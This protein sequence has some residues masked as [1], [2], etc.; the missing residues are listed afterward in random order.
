MAMGGYPYGNCRPGHT[1]GVT[2]FF[3]PIHMNLSCR[4]GV[5]VEE[6]HFSLESDTE[7]AKRI[8][9][10]D[11]QAF[12]RLMQ[13]YREQIRRHLL[14]IVRD[15]AAAEDL[16]QDV[17]LRLWERASQW[18]RK[19][20]FRAWLMRMAT[21]LA[22]NHLRSVR[23]GRER[24]LKPPPVGPDDD[25]EQLAPGWMVD[26]SALG[27]DVI[28]DLTEQREIL[29]G[30]LDALPDEKRDVLQMVYDDQMDLATVAGAL[31]VP[32]GTVKSRLHYTVRWLRRQWLHIQR[33]WESPE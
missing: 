7:L 27:P 29:R 31:G 12:D 9:Q 25:E 11:G 15:E 19:G 18:D 26:A 23:R 14:R 3:P 1:R 4:D 20:P 13:R 17:S 28:A 21:N 32:I 6:G 2:V 33:Q 24:P 10:R 5:I 8:G 22:L 16:T 30:L